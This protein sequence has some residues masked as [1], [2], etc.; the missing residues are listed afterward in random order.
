MEVLLKALGR[1]G[2]VAI[3]GL[4]LSCSEVT[5]LHLNYT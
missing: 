5:K 4:S 1:D 3:A 2:T